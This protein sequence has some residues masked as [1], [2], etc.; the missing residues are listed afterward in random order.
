MLHP[1]TSKIRKWLVILLIKGILCTHCTQTYIEMN[2][3]KLYPTGQKA[4]KDSTSPETVSSAPAGTV[5]LQEWV[6]RLKQ[7]TED[8][9]IGGFKATLQEAKSKDIAKEV[10]N[11]V[12]DEDYG[13]TLL[14]FA[15]SVGYVEVMQLLLDAGAEVNAVARGALSEKGTALHYAVYEGHTDAIKLLV[16]RGAAMNAAAAGNWTALLLAVQE[17]HYEVVDYLLSKGA[18]MTVKEEEGDG[19]WELVEEI[20]D[21]QQKKAMKDLLSHYEKA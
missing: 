14:M 4:T 5:N 1:T 3:D 6:E 21:T 18:D 20:P 13:E 10:V 15:S 2:K 12:L 7:S 16:E 9:D 19:V 17:G 11:A 8:E